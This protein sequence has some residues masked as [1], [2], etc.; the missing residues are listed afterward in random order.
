MMRYTG[1][2][3]CRAA[4]GSIDLEEV[5]I[6]ALSGITAIARGKISLHR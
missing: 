4:D 3:I 1:E 2:R 5:F 6:C